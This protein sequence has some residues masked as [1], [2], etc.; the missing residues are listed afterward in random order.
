MAA[1]KAN[2][3]VQADFNGVTVREIDFVTRFARNWQALRDIMG[4]MRPIKKQTGTKL[5]TYKAQIKDGGSLVGG[6][7]VGEA[8]DIPYTEFEVVPVDYSDI[9]LAKYAKAVSIESVA[10]YGAEIAIQKTDDQFLIELQNKVLTDFYTFLNDTT[11]RTTGTATTWQKA[12]ALAKG[13]VLNKFASMRRNVTDVVGFANLNDLYEYLGEADITV[14]SAFGLNYVKNFLGYSTLFLLS[15]L[16]ITQ[17][18]VIALPVENIDLYYIDPADSDFK[19]LGLD[20]RVDGETNLIGFHAEG[21]YSNAVGES[22]ALMG[23]KLWAEYAD[24]VAI[25]TVDSNP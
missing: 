15:D 13:K 14:Q 22:F 17:G 4:I 19:K 18:T 6:T 24:G 8:E 11:G 3:T 1:E 23:M 25:I 7:S 16:D 10:K 2:T 9:E 21:K 5:V 12:L 20:Y